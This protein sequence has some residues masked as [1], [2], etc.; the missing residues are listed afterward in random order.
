METFVRQVINHDPA[1]LEINNLKLNRKLVHIMCCKWRRR[2]S[3]IIFQLPFSV[4]VWQKIHTWLD[5]APLVGLDQAGNFLK[6]HNTLK[7]STGSNKESVIWM[8]V[9]WN[10]WRARNIK[11][12]KLEECE[13]NE[14]VLMQNLC[15]GYGWLL[16]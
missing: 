5:M 9:T 13:V 7:G 2:F 10:L 16:M 11:I 6:T 1:D 8:T 15:H 14:A 3:L 4:S 12:F